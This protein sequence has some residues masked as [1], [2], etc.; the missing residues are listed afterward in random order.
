MTIEYTKYFS[1]IYSIIS[2]YTTGNNVETLSKLDAFYSKLNFNEAMIN[3]HLI[4]VDSN[5]SINDRLFFKK[6]DLATIR[7]SM[8]TSDKDKVAK[9]VTS[10][11]KKMKTDVA[12]KEHKCSGKCCGNKNG[13]TKKMMKMMKNKGMKKKMEKELGKQMGMKN[14]N[15]EDILNSDFTK[16]SSQGKMIGKLMNNP[17]IKNITKKFLTKENMQ[18]FSEKVKEITQNEEFKAE[19]EK[20]KKVLSTEKVERISK[21]AFETI[22]NMKEIPDMKKIESLISENGDLMELFNDLQK[23]R[24]DGLIDENK[25]MALVMKYKDEM[26]KEFNVDSKTISQITNMANIS[27]LFNMMPSEDNKKKLT[28]EQRRKKSKK[29]YQRKKR[30][31]LKNKKKRNN[32][33]H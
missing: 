1:A 16:N 10:L 3:R 33:K 31:E 13:L 9:I 11:Y 32:R 7:K 29:D 23:A 25:I 12:P 15:L 27:G 8:T 28:Q 18:K 5:V 14:F 4:E 17:K 30:R 24:D 21:F 22:G 19:L 2:K 6:L 20:I 26:L